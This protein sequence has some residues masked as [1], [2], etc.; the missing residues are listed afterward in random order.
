MPLLQ[1]VYPL[2]NIYL[3]FHYP[4]A[5]HY[6][7]INSL[8]EALSKKMGLFFKIIFFVISFG[9]LLVLSMFIGIIV[10]YMFVLIATVYLFL[11]GCFLNSDWGWIYRYFN[12][13][14]NRD[15][16]D[17][18]ASMLSSCKILVFFAIA[19]IGMLSIFTYGCRYIMQ[20]IFIYVI[21]MS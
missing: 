12:L 8:T 20:Q 1:E 14:R 11:G 19:S 2:S 6:Q 15:H 10:R 4:T 18:T 3:Y 9:I 17:D 5:L 13:V 21:P 16:N 7:D